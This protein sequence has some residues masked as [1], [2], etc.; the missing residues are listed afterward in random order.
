VRTH[1]RTA[2]RESASGQLVIASGDRE[3]DG[4][5]FQIPF[6]RRWQRFIKVVQIEDQISLGGGKQ[7]KIQQVAVST[8]LYPKTCTWGSREIVGHERGR[9]AQEREGTAEHTAIADRDQFRQSVL[10]RF[11]RDLYGIPALGRWCPVGVA[12]AR[13]LIAQRL[14]G[15]ETLCA[16]AKNRDILRDVIDFGLGFPGAFIPV[17]MLASSCAARA[18]EFTFA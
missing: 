10:V 17:S 11:L 9:A 13:H 1:S 3:T 16:G 8:G 7:A 5:P 14:T 2:V 6:P 4:Q 15:G 12:A 18:A